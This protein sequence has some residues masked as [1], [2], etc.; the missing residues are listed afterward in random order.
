ALAGVLSC[1][2]IHRIRNRPMGRKQRERKQRKLEQRPRGAAPLPER[3]AWLNTPM[4]PLAQSIVQ[5]LA[6]KPDLT[7]ERAM[8][9]LLDSAELRAEPELASLSF[10]YDRVARALEYVMPRHMDRIERAAKIS[11]DEAQ[12]RYDDARIEMI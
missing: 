3:G 6:V 9:V 11:A 12:Q 1:V 5:R 8:H 4:S 10:D 7:D 2:I